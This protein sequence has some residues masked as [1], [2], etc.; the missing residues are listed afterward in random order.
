MGIEMAANIERI[1]FLLSSLLFFSSS[2]FPRFN[3]HGGGGDKHLRL[4]TLRSN[5]RKWMNGMD[6][7]DLADI[8]G[9]GERDAN[10]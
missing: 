1:F 3:L 9:R 2:F 8:W 5:D 10:E 7:A 6:L 4:G